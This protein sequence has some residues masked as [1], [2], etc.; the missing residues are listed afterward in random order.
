ME[1]SYM[2]KFS[3]EPSFMRTF[4]VERNCMCKFSVEQNLMCLIFRKTVFPPANPLKFFCVGETNIQS[5]FHGI[6]KLFFMP[7]LR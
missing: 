4:S 5:S 2:C 7:H 1:P 6:K 3:V